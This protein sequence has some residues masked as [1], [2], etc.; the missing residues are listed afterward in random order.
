MLGIGSYWWVVGDTSGGRRV[1]KGPFGSR[2]DA[3]TYSAGLLNCH[4]YELHTRDRERAKAEIRHKLTTEGQ[5]HDNVLQRM[6][7]KARTEQHSS[8]L[9]EEL[10][11]DG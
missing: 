8:E 11:G 5:S 10:E 7:S 3:I 1:V 2:D 6:F 9:E 4:Y